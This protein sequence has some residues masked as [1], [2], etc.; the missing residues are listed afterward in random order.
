MADRQA[1]KGRAET[2]HHRMAR[3]VHAE[4][5]MSADGIDRVPLMTALA[6]A[7]DLVRASQFKPPS[8]SVLDRRLDDTEC[9]LMD[10]LHELEEPL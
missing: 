10:L 6:A 1:C 9:A 5:A 7:L 8:G 4:V 3:R 2:D